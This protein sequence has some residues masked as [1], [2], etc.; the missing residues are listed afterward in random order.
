MRVTQSK[1]AE[2]LLEGQVVAIPT[3]TVYGLAAS[4]NHPKAIEKL[5]SLKD[6]PRSNP[7]ITQ[8]ASFEQMENFLHSFPEGME[9]LVEKFWPGILTLVLPVNTQAVL[10]SVRGDL[11][12]AAFRI[13][14][15]PI[16]LSL[17]KETGPLAV[18]S[19]NKSGLPPA[20][21]PE[22]VEKD[23]GGDFPL[24][25]GGNCEGGIE[26]TI[27]SYQDKRWFIERV[28]A[29]SPEDFFEVLNYVPLLAHKHESARLISQSS[30]T[31]K[32]KLHLHTSAYDGSIQDVLGFE[33]RNYLSANVFSLGELSDPKGVSAKLYPLL[34]E[35]EEKGI[36]DLW[37]DMD[38]PTEGILATV[39][40]RLEK[41]ASKKV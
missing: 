27:L 2:L 13:P 24:L 31:M 22:H 30:K 12:T 10:S 35:I 15:H 8:L 11:P 18:P 6:R 1:A 40:S 16:T 29:I 37:V 20:T 5:F 21:S 4:V 3:E 25:D 41:M 33:E 14:G 28:G 9:A 23:F 17:L 7:L 38:F 19:A 39:A 36:S 34:R 32:V 26:S